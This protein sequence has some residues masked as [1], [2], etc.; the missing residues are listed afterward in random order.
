MAGNRKKGKNG[1]KEV[2]KKN[3]NQFDIESKKKQQEQQKKILAKEKE[4]AKIESDSDSD[5][6][7]DSESESGSSSAPDSAEEEGKN[8]HHDS[9]KEVVA[10]FKGIDLDE[11]ESDDEDDDDD[12][13][14]E[15][16]T[17]EQENSNKKASTTASSSPTTNNSFSN[18]NCSFDLR[19]LLA[20]N[21]H[22]I[23][24]RTLYNNKNKGGRDEKLTISPY[25]NDDFATNTKKKNSSVSAGAK[26]CMKYCDSINE[27]YLLQKATDGCTQLLDSL[28]RLPIKNSD[29]GPMVTLPTYDEITLPRALPPPPPKQD[30]KW[31]KFAKEKGIPLNKEKRSQ[32]VWD[33]ETGSWM[34]RHGY[35]KAN[36]SLG[37]EWPIIEVGANDDMYADPWEKMRDEKHAKKTK[38][39]TNQMKNKERA[40]LISKGTTNRMMKNMEETRKKG[41]H[42]GSGSGAGGALPTGV[43]VDLSLSSSQRKLRGGTSTMAALRT[44]QLS[45]SSIGKF[46]KM[47]QDEPERQKPIDAYKN[48]KDVKRKRASTNSGDN[49]RGGMLKVLNSVLTNGGVQK[50]KDRR[51]GKLAYGETAY[52][53]DFNDGLGPSTF[54][55]K[56][57]RAGAGKIGKMTKKR[58]K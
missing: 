40:G 15:V 43:P 16:V 51:K 56:K 44:T 48:K 52:D 3:S 50:E 19:N 36:D 46:D 6:D 8:N 21:S 30:T 53:Y 5:S 34:F 33:E 28:W 4:L 11:E 41:R 47:L 39:T 26:A 32:K 57:G 35:K 13:D 10:V 24:T 25:D 23:D 29:V 12:S 2:N 1:K 45:T 18:E 58:I 49:E 42:G 7:S 27:Q 54:K 20:L 37:K 55:K 31:E 38:N 14:A 22:N 17:K 9:K